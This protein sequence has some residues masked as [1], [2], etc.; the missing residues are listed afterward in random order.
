MHPRVHRVVEIARILNKNYGWITKDFRAFRVAL[1]LLES[2]YG[3]LDRAPDFLFRGP[4]FD[5]AVAEFSRKTTTPSALECTRS[6]V[7]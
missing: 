3:S 6:M 2:L 5:P 7:L 4:M 1:E